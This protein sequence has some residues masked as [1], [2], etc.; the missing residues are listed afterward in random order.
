MPESGKNMGVTHGRF[1]PSPTGLL[2]L[3][4]LRTALIAWLAARADGG[5]FTVRMEDLDRVTSSRDHASRQLE[6][7]R[8]IGLDWD[9]EVVFQS[10]RFNRYHAAIDELAGKG[11]TYPCFC[12]RK[13]IRDAARAPHGAEVPYP[14]T[15]RNLSDAQRAA[16][17]ADGRRP[18]IRLRSNGEHIVFDDAVL[19]KVTGTVDDVVLC[20]NDGVPAY[21][22]AVVVDDAAQGIDLVVRGDDLAPST[23]RQIH[24]GRL[25]G[26]PVPSYAHVPLTVGADGERL[27]KRHGAVTLADLAQ[28]GVSAADVLAMLAHSIGLADAAESVTPRQLVDR[29]SWGR[30]PRE[31]WTVHPRVGSRQS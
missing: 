8:A 28:A 10:D 20:R 19:G 15:C 6:D 12:T 26:L 18:V 13:E 29:F 30:L 3:G 4:N 23:P 1:A 7:L 5:A 9:G 27:A 22:L 11:L 31:P 17:T 21:N 2:H 25:L 16:R 24:L 14:G